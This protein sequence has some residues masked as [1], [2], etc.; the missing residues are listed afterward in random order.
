PDN[1]NPVF[2]QA[3]DPDFNENMDEYV[4]APYD[5]YIEE[6]KKAAPKSKR[7]VNAEALD[8][9]P[10]M[11]DFLYEQYQEMNKLPDIYNR[12]NVVSQQELRDWEKQGKMGIAET[13]AKKRKWEMVPFSGTTADT[14]L[15]IRNANTLRKIKKGEQV[16]DTDL[17]LLVE[18]LRDM[19]ELEVRGCTLGGAALDTLMTCIPYAAEFG[20]SLATL[21]EGVGGAGF[22]KMLATAA[23]KK[24]ARKAVEAAVKEAAVESTMSGVKKTV[25][26]SAAKNIYKT[27]QNDFLKQGITKAA[28]KGMGEV[29]A[30]KTAGLAL[31][32]TPG[33]LAKA[34]RVNMTRIPQHF[35]GGVADRQLS[36]GV[37]ITD[38]GDSVFTQSE[39]LATSIMKS[40]ADTTLDAWT[41]S[42]G[43]GIGGVTGYFA[44]PLRKLLPKT[45]FSGFE[46]LVSSRY[47]M[48]AAEALRKYGYDG[49]IEEM[50]EEQL[51]R[52]LCQVF[53]VNSDNL[54]DYFNFDSFM[55]N[56]FYFDRQGK[57]GMEGLKAG[58]KSAAEGYGTE[59]LS[60]AAMSGGGHITS[61]AVS[62][63][64]E[65]WN[66]NKTNNQIKDLTDKANKLLYSPE[67]FYLDQGFIKIKGSQSLAEQKL[68]DIWTGENVPEG[69]QN[70]VLQSM[71]QYEIQNTLK[72]IVENDSENKSTSDKEKQKQEIKNIFYKKAIA[73]GVSDEQAD[74]LA[75]TVS[76]FA[77]KY[78]PDNIDPKEWISKLN[79]KK[80]IPADKIL[81]GGIEYNDNPNYEIIENKLN[82][83]S[84]Q[85]DNLPDDF[86]DEQTINQYLDEMQV[87]ADIQDGNINKNNI[88]QIQNLIREYKESEPEL[89]G[90]LENTL[91]KTETHFQSAAMY[92]SP[93]ENF[94]EFYNQVFEKEKQ[95]KE[96]NTKLQKS[97]F[98]YT[99][100]KISV[101]VPHDTVA[102]D[103]NKHNLSADEWTNIL[104]N[105]SNIENAGISKKSNSND[106]VALLKINTPNGKYGV[107]IQFANGANQISTAFKSTDKGIDDWIKKGSANRMTSEPSSSSRDDNTSN[108]V[109]LVSQNL[110]D[111]IS[112]IKERIKSN[113]V[114]SYF[115]SA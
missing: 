10:E 13:W 12:L 47:G 49:V 106:K 38:T 114:G 97:Y 96:N 69:L 9:I 52:L 67:Q 71:S 80:N 5:I 31:K 51:S 21:P 66:K 35:V 87:L 18:Q 62:K 88:E 85:Y 115:Q 56:V 48:P 61:G 84:K 46:K 113:D 59:A 25:S 43:W 23:S 72:K 11:P 6:Q 57:E 103:K 111:I 70:S 64:V 16:S 7:N 112:Y 19:K 37:Y 28:V 82:Q 36:R 74:A 2:S 54:S 92:K 40:F 55:N 81:K 45:F 32:A 98:D 78:V 101:R 20:I 34:V 8:D 110:N 39:N 30:L 42:M 109:A 93:K 89:A 90:A 22:A 33:S 27:A 17:D 94:A 63:G 102:H 83:L 41:E 1:V 50:G 68:R 58:L 4:K 15:V 3:K 95:A 99:D 14:T 24:A 60:F 79:I 29:G 77:Q 107:T 44:K 26:L 73:A 100:G 76:F 105:L 91:N 108:A 86:N 104:E 53:G 75:Q 65:Q